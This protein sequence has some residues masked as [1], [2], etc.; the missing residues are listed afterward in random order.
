MTTRLLARCL[1][2]ALWTSALVAPIAHAQ[3]GPPPGMP[4]GPPPPGMPM[5]GP[6]MGPMPGMGSMADTHYDTALEVREGKL[7]NGQGSATLSDGLMLNVSRDA[8]NGVFISGGHSAFTLRNATI[9][10]SGMGKNDFLGIGA[11]ALVRD[12]AALVVDHVT[13]ETA[14]ATA[15]ALVAAENATLRVYDS[16]LIAHGGPLPKGYVR[17][18]G[19]G[20][21]EPPPPLGLDGDARAVLG[22]SNSRSYFY[23]TTVEAD[24]WGALSTD[25]TG[26]NLYLEANDCTLRIA[27]RGYGTYADFGAHV[28]L[29]R[30][31]VDSG[32]E[33]AIMAGKSRIDLNHVTGKAGR[34]G[35]MIHSVMAFNANEISE[36]NLVETTLTTVG[37][38]L[39]VKSANADITVEGGHFSSAAGQLLLARKNEDPNA[40]Q[41][42][43]AA[44]P[45]VTLTLRKADLAG[46][47][48]NIDPDRTVRLQLEGTKLTGALHRVIFAADAGS[49]WR[50]TGA[51]DIE[52]AAGA[53]LAAIDAPTG[54]T[55]TAT[56]AD[57]A[58]PGRRTLP[59]GGVLAI[60]AH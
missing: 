12:D 17:H 5:M 46:D 25:A 27:Q 26:G 11:G 22:M 47:V 7:V 40:T 57:P 43:G 23:R 59:S 30:T 56:S 45:G 9:H 44:V 35:V 53:N 21:M 4:P 38:A 37:P 1:S 2:A 28:V 41:T 8:F 13:I 55:I 24:G 60:G 33:V 20:M 54:V 18:I 58:L 10:L 51:S 49:L 19:P 50:A 14:G 32:G 29:N 31:S 15:S 16:H 48:V 52:L 3:N 34:N 36:L 39:L 42:H 6:G